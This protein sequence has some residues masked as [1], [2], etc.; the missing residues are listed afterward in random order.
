MKNNQIATPPEP[1]QAAVMALIAGL[2]NVDIETEVEEDGRIIAEISALPGCMVYGQTREEAL[3]K[4]QA[5]ALR[6][7]ADKIEHGELEINGAMAGL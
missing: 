2:A 4:V 3:R 6:V 7:I 1:G 5:L